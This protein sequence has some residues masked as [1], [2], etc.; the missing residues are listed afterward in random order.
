MTLVKNLDEEDIESLIDPT[1]AIV[2]EHWESFDAEV[3]QNAHDMISSLLKTHSTM[4]RDMVTTIPSLGNIPL[5]KKFETEL[6]R[7]KAQMDPKHQFQAF[8]KRCQSENVTV[9]ARALT[10]LH[11]YLEEHQS[12][13]HGSAISEQPDPVIAAL[14]HSLLQ[15]CLKFSQVKTEVAPNAARC[16]GMIGCLDPTKIELPKES[17]DILVLSD[18]TNPEETI[19]FVVFFLQEVLVKSF[20]S[21]TDTRSQGLFAYAIQELLRNC[22]FDASNTL[23]KDLQPDELYRRWMVVPE[24]IRNT[25]TP[26][27]MSKY[28]LEPLATVPQ[29]HYPIYALEMSHS[30]WIRQ[31]VFDLLGKGHGKNASMVFSICRRIVR[32]QD[33]S[34]ATFILPFITL[35]IVLDGSAKQVDN[36]AAEF[37][38]ILSTPLHEA[39]QLQR[40]NLILCSHVSIPLMLRESSAKNC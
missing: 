30:T 28:V 4:V 18:F 6:G 5:L 8:V 32:R 21:T 26:F 24:T 10:E 17:Q 11:R 34:V 13:L 14:V 1:F 25:L 33:I 35:N 38:G 12:F 15:V 20:L 27:L 23:R 39:N 19:D 9:V 40:E 29:V 7:L 2:A 37:L 31:F 22:G 36:V 16:L 3:Q